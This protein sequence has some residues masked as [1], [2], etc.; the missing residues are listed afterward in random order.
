MV[1]RTKTNSS[2]SGEQDGEDLLLSLLPRSTFIRSREGQVRLSLERRAPFFAPVKDGSA[3][4]LCPR[5]STRWH[6]SQGLD[7]AFSQPL[8]IA[9]SLFCKLNDLLGDDLSDGI[10]A[11][12]QIELAQRSLIGGY[13]QSNLFWSERSVLQESGER[14]GK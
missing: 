2:A 6:V 7:R 8:R 1:E 4:S 5:S 13:E 14:H 11:P 12:R 10:G 9:L 3:E